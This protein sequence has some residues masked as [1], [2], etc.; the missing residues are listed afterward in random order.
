M[1]VCSYHVTQAFQSESALYSCLNVKELLIRNRRHSRRI[2]DCSRTQIHNRL[3]CKQT[4][5]H[6]AKLAIVCLS[7]HLAKPTFVCLSGCGF[8]SCCSHLCKNI[9]RSTMYLLFKSYLQSLYTCSLVS[10]KLSSSFEAKYFLEHFSGIISFWAKQ[11]GTW[12]DK[13][14]FW[15]VEGGPPVPHQG[16][17]CRLPLP[18]IS[19]NSL[20][21]WEKYDPHPLVSGKC[22]KINSPFVK[23]GGFQV[24]SLQVIL[25]TVVFFRKLPHIYILI[26]F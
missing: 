26:N 17:P 14:N 8:E 12:G 23:G 1:T 9:L 3:V 2:S 11:W 5:N 21:L 16:K 24:C 7:G 22:R 25:N 18:S 10:A 15:L 20:F 6:L 13:S 4:L 19:P